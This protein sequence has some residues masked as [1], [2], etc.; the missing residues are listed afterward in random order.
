MRGMSGLNT[1]PDGRPRTGVILLR[2]KALDLA[3]RREQ[4]IAVLEDFVARFPLEEQVVEMV[5]ALK[6]NA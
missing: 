4:A 3:G 2:A 1:G 6:S 5:K